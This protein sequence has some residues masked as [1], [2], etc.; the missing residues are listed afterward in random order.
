MREERTGESEN[1]MKAK[2]GKSGKDGLRDEYDFSRA[3][4]GVYAQRFV[5][6]SNVVILQPDVAQGFLHFPSSEFV[7]SKADSTA[8]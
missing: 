5:E 2:S 4:R 6:G 1:F 7:S 8:E 3:Q